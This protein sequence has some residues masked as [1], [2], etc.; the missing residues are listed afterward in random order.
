MRG[1]AASL[2][3]RWQPRTVLI[4]IVLAAA[5]FLAE[6]LP[7]VASSRDVL[8]PPGPAHWLGTNDIGQDVLASLLSALPGT[9]AIPFLAA[10]AAM[11]FAGLFAA[12]A[13]GGGV[14]RM[15]V[16]RC[17]DTL[18]ALPSLF[19]LLLLATW[20]R[21]GPVGIVLILCLTT[22]HSDVRVLC[23][24]ALRETSR[25]S[26]AHARR[27]GAGW[28]YCFARHVLPAAWP[29]VLGLYVQN[30]RGAVMR[31]AGLGFLGL[32]DPRFVTWGGMLHEG[33]AHL[34]G[35]EWWWLVLPPAL[36]L[37]GLIGG[38]VLWGQRAERR[39]MAR[40][41]ALA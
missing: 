22:W 1:A 13:L 27:M 15:M 3:T 32:T 24:V 14:A 41:D 36:A 6:R 21:P 7:T 28:R 18:Q 16:L 38:L 25:D 34:Y 23:A 35:P 29:S 33:M 37:S 12:A 26:V 8:Q 40:E 5:V 4:P 2:L 39:A 9:V 17:V 30:L 31:L 11:L 20:I 10:L 19:F